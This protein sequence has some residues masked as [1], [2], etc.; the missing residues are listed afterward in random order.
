MTVALVRPTTLRQ[1]HDILSA[2]EDAHILAGGVSMVLLMSAG[3]LEPS[4]LV[5]LDRVAGLDGVAIVDH[6]LDIGSRTTH[7]TLA[8]HPLMHELFAATSEMFSLIGNIRVRMAGT[9]GGNLAHADP[10]QDPAVMLSVLGAHVVVAGPTGERTVALNDLADGPLSVTLDHT[11]IITRVRIPLPHEGDS[12]AYTKFL[13]GTHDDYATVS[14]GCR[15]QLTTSGEVV[16][17][18]LA[19]GA[20]GPTTVRLDDA[21]KVLI[22]TQPDSAVLNELARR[23]SES[24]TPHNDRRGRADYKRAMTGVVAMRT[25]EKALARQV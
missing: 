15:L 17:A 3:F 11:E 25:V 10:A 23:V 12:T 16:D 2:D 18:S 22:G 24:V 4:T 14:V 7:H 9:V 21:A 1:A 8:R 5:S 13:A 6:H 20:V 19:A